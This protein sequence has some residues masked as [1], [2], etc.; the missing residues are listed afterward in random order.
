MTSA[1]APLL[2]LALL[3]PSAPDVAHD[4]RIPILLDS[5]ANNELDDQHAIAYMVFNGDVFNVAGI[6]INRTRFGGD[7]RAQAEEARRVVTLCGVAEKVAV[8]EGADGDFPSIE[9]SLD[10]ASYDGRAAVDFIV[11]AA[12]GMG[13]PRNRLVL[14]PIGK[15][16]NIALALKRDPSIASLVRVVWL[17][18]NYPEPGEYNQDNDE[19]ALT[20]V[21]ETDVPFEIAL[22]RYGKPSGTAAVTVSLAEI[23]ERMPGRG[24]RVENPVI[25][26]NGGSFHTFGDYSVDLFEHIELQGDPPSRALYDMAALSIIKNPA[27]ARPTQIPAP[28]LEDGAWV[29][30]PDNPR[31][32][33]LWENFDREAIMADFYRVMNQPALATD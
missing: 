33:T 9:G 25:G 8:V 32:I 7:V 18:S 21:L 14:A 29:E 30:Q 4:G 11:E 22:V 17:G 31:M 13:T 5:D 23:R 27:W 2:S 20:Y 15:L 10:E 12:H 1:M 28:R 6:T 3:S 26:R 16:T 24:P 19:A